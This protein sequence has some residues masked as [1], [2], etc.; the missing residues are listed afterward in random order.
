MHKLDWDVRIFEELVA[1]NNLLAT[2]L[3]ALV[4]A[5]WRLETHEDEGGAG[6]LVLKLVAWW[7]GGT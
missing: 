1:L 2:G 6:V 4:L 7:V 5:Q 3:G